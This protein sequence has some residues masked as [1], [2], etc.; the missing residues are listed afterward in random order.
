MISDLSIAKES[1]DLP[2][3]PTYTPASSVHLSMRQASVPLFASIRQHCN[4]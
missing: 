1:T 3:A 2:R 4:P